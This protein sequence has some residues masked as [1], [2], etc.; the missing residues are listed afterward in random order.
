MKSTIYIL[1]FSIFFSSVVVASNLP[2]APPI[3]LDEPRLIWKPQPTPWGPLT[4]APVTIEMKPT[5]LAPKGTPPFVM[6]RL[7]TRILGASLGG[8]V[9]ATGIVYSVVVD[10]EGRRKEYAYA[11]EQLKKEGKP[12]GYMEVAEY[13]AQKNGID[14]SGGG[15]GP[16]PDGDYFIHNGVRY[17]I[18]ETETSTLLYPSH[19]NIPKLPDYLIEDYGYGIKYS[20]CVSWK[21]EPP[22]YYTYTYW[23]VSKG[24]STPVGF[25]P[26]DY[27]EI[28]GPENFP[29]NAIDALFEQGI[30]NFT[31]EMVRDPE[32]LDDHVYVEVEAISDISDDDGKTDAWSNG[33]KWKMP[34]RPTDVPKYNAPDHSVTVSTEKGDTVLS[35]ADSKPFIDSGIPE[36]SKIIKVNPQSGTVTYINPSTGKTETTQVSPSTATNLTNNYP[37]YNTYTNNTS[38][39]NI[40]KNLKVELPEVKVSGEI[41]KPEEVTLEPVSEDRIAEAKARFFDSWDTLKATVSDIFTAN[42]SGTGRLPVWTWQVLGHTVIIDFNKYS[43]ELNWIGLAGLFMAS[44]S[45]IFIVLGK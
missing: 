33:N 7:L 10:L 2:P 22:T 27:P 36:G 26:A 5:E 15:N 28:Y 31:I 18:L 9:A 25:D 13:L 32:M 34:F 6:R 41:K 8:Y 29:R 38:I 42:L 43:T 12:Y 30:E 17:R 37:V 24:D 39:T 45:A 1:I 11:M 44:L 35:N 40:N 21:D 19:W 16:S 23:I 20:A 3:E 14:T 4:D